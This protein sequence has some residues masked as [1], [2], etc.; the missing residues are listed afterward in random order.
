MDGPI[1]ILILILALQ[2]P[3]LLLVLMLTL[4]SRRQKEAQFYRPYGE[5]TFY[6][7]YGELTGPPGPLEG[8]HRS[9]RP[10]F[11]L[12]A[13]LGLLYPFLF[14]PFI[15]SAV[16]VVPS[17]WIIV[18]FGVVMLIQLLSIGGISDAAKGSRSPT[19]RTAIAYLTVAG[20][21]TSGIQAGWF[22]LV[23]VIT[24][25]FVLWWC[26]AALASAA[27]GIAILWGGRRIGQARD[28]AKAAG[29]NVT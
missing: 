15:L 18:P 21:M 22:V 3:L 9:R 19:T 26:A 12:L 28:V 5:F 4:I 25:I 20:V 27:I 6:K 13:G 8:Y 11:I 10:V 14:I 23:A 1:P 16:Y 7:P 24:G 29:L 17:Y 2:L